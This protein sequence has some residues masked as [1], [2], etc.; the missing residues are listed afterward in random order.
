M[1]GREQQAVHPVRIAPECVPR[2]RREAQ[3]NSGGEVERTASPRVRD[4]PHPRGA[5]QPV[6]RRNHPPGDHRLSGA[7]TAVDADPRR[8][9]NDNCSLPDLVP[10]LGVLRDSQAGRVRRGQARTRSTDR[11][12]REEEDA[13][14][15]EGK[16]KFHLED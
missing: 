11:R 5:V 10:V 8:T 9:Q 3:G 16:S 6:L 2:G 14:L 4:L 7:R 15:G 12:T 13:A 1:D